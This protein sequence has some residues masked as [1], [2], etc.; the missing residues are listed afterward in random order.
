M[1]KL[2]FL[3]LLII[4]VSL[5]AACGGG[6]GG[7]KGKDEPH[8]HSYGDWVTILSPTCTTKGSRERV[9]ECGEKEE[10]VISKLPH[11]YG[12]YYVTKPASCIEDGVR[13]AECK[14]CDSTT[15]QR[16]KKNEAHIR[17]VVS[18]YLATCTE[19][20]LT[21]GVRCTLCNV[22]IEEQ[23][24]I[25]SRGHV[26]LYDS[27]QDP[28]CTEN[29]LT[30]G[31]HCG[32]CGQVF[33][34]Q[35]VIEAK[36]HTVEVIPAASAT[37]TEDGLTQGETCTVCGEITISQQ[38][39][40]ALGHIEKVIPGIEAT[41]TRGGFTDGVECGR[42]NQVLIPQYPTPVVE[43]TYDDI[44]DES[45]NVC[46]A[47]R[48]TECA[49][50]EVLVQPAVDPG[51]TTPG[52]TRGEKCGKC[53]EILIA[54]T[55]IDPTGHSSENVEGKAPTCTEGGLT[56]G[57][58][59]S[60]CGITLKDQEPISA[61]GHS[62]KYIEGYESTCTNEGLSEGCICDVCGE[63]LIEQTTLSPKGH[64]EKVIPGVDASCEKNGLTEGKIC[65]DCGEVTV[66]QSVIVAYGHTEE[67]IPAV[68]ASCEKNGLTEGKICSVCGTITLA[69]K[70]VI[71]GHTIVIDPAVAPTCQATGLT[72]GAHCSVCGTV[73]TAQTTLPVSDCTPGEW[74]A[75]KEVTKT[76]DGVYHTS[77][78]VCGKE[79]TK[80]L[81]ATGSLGLEYTLNDDGESYTVSGRGAC[82]DDILVIPSYYNG[83]PVT[84]IGAGAISYC[85][86]VKVIILDGVKS[87]GDSAF[88][89]SSALTTVVIPES[90]EYIGSGAF[91]ACHSLIEVCNKSS[92]SNIYPGSW[93]HGNIAEYAKNVI[94][95]EADS[96][97]KFVDDFIFY[98]DGS[99]VYLV[100]YLN[101]QESIILPEY[102]RSYDYKIYSYAFTYCSLLTDV[103]IPD[104]ITYI[105]NWAFSYC[106]DLINISIPDSVS[107]VG[108]LAFLLCDK[109]IQV[110]GGVSYIDKWAIDF[111]DSISNPTLRKDTV[112]IADDSFNDCKSLVGVDMPDSLRYIGKGAF[113]YSN[114]LLNIVI[115]EGVKAIEKS[116]FEGCFSLT[117]VVI[118]SNVADIEAMAFS[119][120]YSLVEICNKSS[121]D[122]TI[123]SRDF[124]EIGLYAKH[125]ISDESESYLKYVDNFIF[126]DTGS[127]VYLVKYIGTPI[128]VVLP[129]YNGGQVY[130]ICDYAFFGCTSLTSIVIPDSV[131]VIGN[132]AF[133]GCNKLGNVYYA[134]TSEKWAEI[135]MGWNNEYLINANM[136]FEYKK[137]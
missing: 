28:T 4:I 69:Q 94:T 131:T 72:E 15:T 17:E 23:V 96:N 27:P 133:D 68:S 62:E 30:W 109:A 60:K 67:I 107:H 63:V 82:M 110:D 26:E 10:S 25:E 36:G 19:D 115:P 22:M 119:A 103:V 7:D 3:L 38:I 58:R 53:G 114:H 130:E 118:G 55:I 75:E 51:C 93:A 87:I 101:K 9:C 1:K 76:E 99:Q 12:E 16:I 78:T 106:Y 35:L 47:I 71:A 111:D 73:T 125:I 135:S 91:S 105:G 129:E 13:T 70:T 66:E 136:T 100:K 21:D 64:N 113:A 45:C 37:C 85:Y 44:Y 79:M 123:G 54:Q 132:F 122:I 34:G 116:T 65:D 24:V 33:V 41:C 29:G 74:I 104:G 39:I 2:C 108:G 86:A 137:N 128:D 32:V 102:N 20:G 14:Y 8:V 80:T 92:L 42:C 126:I 84:D 120:C 57:V 98:D 90:I 127:S 31:S 77:C 48:D 59:C 49:H 81:H 56:S 117:N 97:L 5:L 18:G 124:G 61:K 134:G 50:R 40:P 6:D 112:G 121:L 89:Y 43:H 95:D 83:Y 11:A 52:L 88:H 46:G